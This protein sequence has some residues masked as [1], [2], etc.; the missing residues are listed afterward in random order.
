MIGRKE[1]AAIVLLRIATGWHFLYEGLVKLT[2]P[3]FSAAAYLKGSEGVIRYIYE[4]YMHTPARMFWVDTI[5]ITALL[6][7]GAGLLFGVAIRKSAF[8]GMIL[9]FLYY[10]A[11]PPFSGEDSI[12]GSFFIVDRNLIEF[13]VLFYIAQTPVAQN[14]SISKAWSVSTN[15]ELNSNNGK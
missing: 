11:Y 10:S 1:K 13:L 8:A 5:N 12:G 2:D 3:S 14:F 15:R 6:M 4:H 9:L 7:V